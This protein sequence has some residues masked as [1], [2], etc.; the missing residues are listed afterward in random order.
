M[1]IFAPAESLPSPATL[2]PT[3]LSMKQE[4]LPEILLH[5]S[6]HS[7]MA[8]RETPFHRSLGGGIVFKTSPKP[9]ALLLMLLARC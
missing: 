6:H 4:H 7:V 8:A 2:P 9:E 5:T 3:H 1:A